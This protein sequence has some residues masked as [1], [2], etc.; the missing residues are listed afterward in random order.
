MEESDL[1][2]LSRYHEKTSAQES[3]EIS[4]RFTRI[5]RRT[6]HKIQNAHPGRSSI[7]TKDGA[8]RTSGTASPQRSVLTQ[9]QSWTEIYMDSFWLPCALATAPILIFMC[10]GALF[11]SERQAIAG[12]DLQS[13]G[14]RAYPPHGGALHTPAMVPV[15]AHTPRQLVSPSIPGGLRLVSLSGAKVRPQLHENADILWSASDTSWRGFRPA[16]L[17]GDG[18]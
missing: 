16:A 2:H 12:F 15:H 6:S 3:D 4:P 1:Y 7:G 14:A 11:G 13:R 17:N 8:G 18:D 5:A 9:A 10:C